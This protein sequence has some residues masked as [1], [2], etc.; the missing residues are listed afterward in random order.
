[1]NGQENKSTPQSHQPRF[2]K[3]NLNRIASALFLVLLFAQSAAAYQGVILS[4]GPDVDSLD[5]PNDVDF[6]C[7]RPTFLDKNDIDYFRFTAPAT[8]TVTI[9]ANSS[10]REDSKLYLFE[11]NPPRLIETD[12]DGGSDRRSAKIEFRAASGHTY[13][14][15]VSHRRSPGICTLTIDSKELVIRH[16]GSPDALGL[17]PDTTAYGPHWSY[18]NDFGYVRIGTTE[19][20][21]YQLESYSLKE[22][23]I[24]S[25]ELPAP[26]FHDARNPII[27]TGT[28]PRFNIGFAP[29][30]LTN[31]YAEGR[32][33]TIEYK[34]DGDSLKGRY[35]LYGNGTLSDGSDPGQASVYEG[36]TSLG[37]VF[38]DKDELVHTHIIKAPDDRVYS[39]AVVYVM[40][41]DPRSDM[42]LVGSVFVDDETHATV[43]MALGNGYLAIVDNVGFDSEIMIK[44]QLHP[45][46]VYA[47]NDDDD[48][49]YSLPFEYKMKVIFDD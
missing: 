4:H 38:T 32:D 8:M 13:I 41:T 45:Y 42:E 15:G 27:G 39:R 36:N 29:N 5:K 9:R 6:P 30:T 46:T 16:L 12:D 3:N 25:M 7:S 37:D 47:L 49:R 1:M 2:G 48:G 20:R 23:E 21:R 43:G 44:T 28:Y 19:T 40:P 31:W 24:S 33:L 26:F 10:F 35:A 34:V 17:G 18:G 14:V 22:V 11:D